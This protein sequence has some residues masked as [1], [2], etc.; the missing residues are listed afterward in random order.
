[1]AAGWAKADGGWAYLME[2]STES[3]AKRVAEDLMMND[4]DEYVVE[5][6]VVG[7]RTY[8]LQGASE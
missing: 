7:S 5:G 4:V 1:M 6:A 2:P 3:A 8:A